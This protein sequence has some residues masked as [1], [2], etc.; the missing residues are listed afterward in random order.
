ME[1]GCFLSDNL[2]E[3]AL[4]DETVEKQKGKLPIL[5]VF[6]DSKEAFWTM[7]AG[8]KGPT[9]GGVKFCVDRLEDSGY[10]GEAITVKSDQEESIVALRRAIS[11]AR[12]GDTVP[13]NSPVRCSKSNGEME[14]AARTF[15]G[16]LRVEIP[17]RKGHRKEV[18]ECF[19]RVLLAYC[20]GIGGAEQVQN[21]KRWS[22]A[23]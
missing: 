19:S 23:I 8:Q 13:I 16:Q 9:E 11:A 5:V 14:R 10:V 21:R 1:H 18:A 4:D 20:L 17:F 12:V 7:P 3:D 6:D 22:N 15:Q 2:E